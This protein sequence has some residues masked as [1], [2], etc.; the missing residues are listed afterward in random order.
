M[1]LA[2]RTLYEIPT[3]VTPTAANIRTRAVPLN[4]PGCPSPDDVRPF[5]V[6][7]YRGTVYVGLTCTAESTTAGGTTDG[8]PA[9]L[10]AYVYTVDPVTLNFSA[11]PVLTV[12]LTYPRACADGAD[13]GLANCFR[14]TWK[15]WTP[16]YRNIAENNVVFTLPNGTE[17]RRSIYPQPWLTSIRFDRGNLLLGIRDRMGDQ[18][19][20]VSEDNPNTTSLYYG[21]A[22]G[23]I[24]RAC[25]SPGTGWSLENNASCG[26]ITTGGANNGQGPGN[27]EYYFQDKSPLYN[28]EI[29][30]GSVIQLAG[31]PDMLS[32]VFHPIPIVPSSNDTTLFDGG[33]RWFRNSSGT[34]VKNYRIYDNEVST[35][36]AFGKSNG[37]GDLT[38]LLDLQQVEVGNY[39]WYDV[40]KNGLQDP[41]EAVIAGLTVQLFRI[42][43]A[44][45]GLKGTTTTNGAGQYY[46]NNSNV[47]EGILPGEQYE[48]RI[49]LTGA[50]QGILGVRVPTIENAAGTTDINDSDGT[51][52]SGNDVIS[53]I[54]PQYG[55]NDHTFDFGFSDPVF[56]SD[57]Q[58]TKSAAPNCVEPGETITY[59]VRVTNLGPKVATGVTVVDTLPTSLQ[60]QSVTTSQGSCNTNN[61]PINCSLG[62]LGVGSTATIT[63]RMKVPDN[64]TQNKFTNTARVSGNEPDPNPGNNQASATSCIVV[65]GDPNQSIGPGEVFPISEIN[66]QKPG[67]VLIFNYYT[68]NPSSPNLQNSRIN[69]TNTNPGMFV[70]LHL[71]WVDGSTCTISNNFVCLTKNQ[72]ISI[73]A[74]DLDPGTSGYLVAVAVDQV[75]GCPIEFNHLIGDA[76]VKLQSGHAANLQAE[77][78]ARIPG[79]RATCDGNTVTSTLV[80]DGAPGNYNQLPRVIAASSVPDLQSGND[81]LLV[82]NAIGGNFLSGAATLPPLFGILYNDAEVSASFTIPASSCQ[83]RGTLSNSFPKTTPPYMTHIAAGTNGWLKVGSTTA[84]SILGSVIVYNP[85]TGTSPTAINQG[86][87][88]H[89]L[90]FNPTTTITVPVFPPN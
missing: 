80:F 2:N 60:L 47:A 1:N 19:G 72:T 5:A 28:D 69:I 75:T 67:S 57:L 27:G 55:A 15:P 11:S 29:S 10:A 24:L 22:P 14:A 59:T 43:G 16:V 58:I 63:I 61:N 89:K 34:M 44:N 13:L 36:P 90:T 85:N 86:R 40:N 42:S 84:S 23:D 77:S 31:Y 87:N 20:L 65:A 70:F 41:N 74:S 78:I 51:T 66:D 79:E 71:F 7:Y 8:N 3:N 30:M 52:V 39:V 17:V 73:L 82:I 62:Q 25:G 32:A 49:P 81:T 88:L 83:L 37:L 4:P 48:I 53:F 64:A 26:G 33:V 68:S 35:A 38:A 45:P 9:S 54:G 76:Y 6:S 18:T 46:F 12:P 56:D 21:V 50:N